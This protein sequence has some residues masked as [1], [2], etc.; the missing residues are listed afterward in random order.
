MAPVAG[1]P[2]RYPPAV[3]LLHLAFIVSVAA[4]G[5]S[6]FYIHYLPRPWV[7]PQMRFIHYLAMYV[8]MLAF[9]ARV[10]YAFGSNRRDYRKFMPRRADLRDLRPT[11]SHYLLLRPSRAVSSED[12]RDDGGHDP[13]QKA[14]YLMWGALIVAQA[15]TG[16][17][18]YSS[19]SDTLGWVPAILG[20]LARVRTMHF[21]IAWVLLCS[22]TVHIY[23][24]LTENAGETVKMFR[25]EG[26]S[27]R[28]SKELG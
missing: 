24:S 10:Y 12:G 20:G 17:A 2:E 9:A 7:L 1:E 11:I 27:S 26:M 28:E 3:R 13:L 23:L 19:L 22:V 5:I 15:A 21:L 8:L 4:A 25:G 6:G 18:M 14:V 16:L